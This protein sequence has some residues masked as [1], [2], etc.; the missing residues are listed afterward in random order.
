MEIKRSHERVWAGNPCEIQ[1]IC[2]YQ[3]VCCPFTHHT[4]SP[5]A[6]PATPAWLGRPKKSWSHRVTVPSSRRPPWHRLKINTSYF[7]GDVEMNIKYSCNFGQKS[8]ASRITCDFTVENPSDFAKKE[9]LGFG[10]TPAWVK[11][12][13]QPCGTPWPNTSLIQADCWFDFIFAQCYV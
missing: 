10:D 9:V 8:S 5:R 6:S 13:Q 1:G 3:N 4:L 11:Q 2:L 12:K 7:N